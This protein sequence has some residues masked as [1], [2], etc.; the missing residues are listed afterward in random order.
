LQFSIPFFTK[1]LD[2]GNFTVAAMES[3]LQGCFDNMD[4][5]NAGVGHPDWWKRGSKAS[6]MNAAAINV[7]SAEMAKA[8]HKTSHEHGGAPDMTIEKL[9]PVPTKAGDLQTQQLKV[10]SGGGG[11]LRAHDIRE[12]GALH[13]PGVERSKDA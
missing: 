4:G 6:G 12:C 5:E 11:L 1:L 13:R 10:R 8:L 7:V 3:M 2:K 9:V